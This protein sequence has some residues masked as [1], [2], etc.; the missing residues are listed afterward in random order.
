MREQTIT[1]SSHETYKYCN[2]S[3]HRWPS[4]GPIIRIASCT[5]YMEW[6][7]NCASIRISYEWDDK[8]DE[9]DWIRESDGPIIITDPRVNEWVDS[10]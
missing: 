5:T 3:G 4:T 6:C 9:G 2:E 8:D 7:N 10:D 1:Y